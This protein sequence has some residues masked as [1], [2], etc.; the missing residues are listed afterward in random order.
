M[1]RAY[2]QTKRAEAAAETR[3]RI[4]E[5]VV[6]LHRTVGPRATTIA[7]I[8]RRA[9]VE[10]LT[11]YKH[12]PDEAGLVMATQTHWLTQHPPPDAGQWAM[13]IDPDAR[14]RVALRELYLWYSDTEEMTENVMRDGPRLPSFA[15]VLSLL[16]EHIREG[17]EILA[18]GRTSDPEWTIA[19]LNVVQSFETWRVLVKERGLTL[20]NAV[21]LAISWMRGVM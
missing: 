20:G 8:A 12:F 10:R 7:E 13:I 11:V 6:E 16:R 14:L 1:K 18:V 19:T 15:A 5:V 21:E 2:K 9:G 17:A 3:Q 4:V